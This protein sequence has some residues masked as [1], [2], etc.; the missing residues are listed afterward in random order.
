MSRQPELLHSF[1]KYAKRTFKGVFMPRCGVM[2]DEN[3]TLWGSFLRSVFLVRKAI[4]EERDAHRD[5]GDHS[6]KN[7]TCD[8]FHRLV[9]IIP[10]G[11]GVNKILK[12]RSSISLVRLSFPGSPG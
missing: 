3:V 2:F 6:P 11:S 5:T 12:D 1:A 8:E 4:F 10:L 9:G 7:T